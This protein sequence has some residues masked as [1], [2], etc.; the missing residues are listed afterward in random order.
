MLDTM[1]NKNDVLAA[2]RGLASQQASKEKL[3]GLV[4]DLFQTSADRGTPDQVDMCEDVLT[5]LISLVE[6]EAR[7]RISE[8]L[9]DLETAPRRVVQY[10][11]M[12][13]IQVAQPVL[14]KSPVLLDEDLLAVV[15]Q[16]GPHHLEAIAERKT[17]S[18]AVTNELMR[19]GTIEVWERLA[20]NY[21]AELADRSVTFLANRAR[22][23]KK[24]QMGLLERP[25]LP[26]SVITRL[27]SE[28]SDSVRE[29]LAKAGRKDLLAHFDRAKAVAQKR[30]LSMSSILGF[31]YDTAFQV[32]LQHEQVKKLTHQ[33]ILDAARQ[34]NFPRVC[35]IFSRIS[36]LPLE[37]A[38]HWLSRREVDPAIVAFKA[39]D[40]DIE[41]VRAML[42]TGPWRRILTDQTRLRAIQAHSNLKPEVAKRIFQSRNASLSSV[43]GHA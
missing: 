31:E 8:R 33:D 38:V 22:E 14:C 26:E 10:L 3:F 4:F 30:V 23:N 1:E 32:V 9:A 42:K 13:P 36:G 15:R 21:G 39:L 28:A 7:V 18:V 24:I 37:D 29:Q 6:I 35:G 11:A 34:D 41:L 20:H 27:V 43:R 40:F 19:V 25:N 12:E 17:V 2:L 16:C 5:Q